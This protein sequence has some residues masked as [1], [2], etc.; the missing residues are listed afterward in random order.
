MKKLSKKLLLFEDLLF[1]LFIFLIPSQLAYH[2]W[3]N[4]AFLGGVRVDYYAPAIYL[5]D[6]LVIAFLTIFV[7]RTV[8]MKGI[9]IR[10][11]S[12]TI[13]ILGV[14]TILI[15]ANIYYSLLPILSLMKWLKIFEL[16]MIALYIKGRSTFNVRKL[17]VIPLFYSVVVF[18]VIG[19]C[20]FY[21]QRS[22]GGL[23]YMLGERSFTADTIGIAVVNIFGVERLRMYSTFPHPN[24]LAGYAG[25]VVIL[26]LVSYK[27]KIIT[28]GKSLFWLSILI[29]GIVLFLTFSKT[30]YLSIVVV[31]C[32]Y[33]LLRMNQRLFKKVTKTVF[34]FIVVL[35][36]L[37]TI[38]S[39]P[40][41]NEGKY[42]TVSER[43]VLA[44][45]A[46]EAFSE[47]IVT[48][49]GMNG[50]IVQL[51]KRDIPT[52]VRW[53]LQP[54]H[55]IY[56]L[57]LSEMGLL[58]FIIAIFALFKVLAMTLEIKSLLIFPYLFILITGTLD[59]YWITLQQN[60]L[61]A[62][63]IIAVIIREYY[64]R[65]FKRVGGSADLL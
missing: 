48:G 7:L 50:Y 13:V 20:Q 22:I 11:R 54:V 39:S 6:I 1:I 52:S 62:T 30:A 40:V 21:Y 25:V 18:G 37:F 53:M 12:S 2:F 29:L 47:N 24:A 56:L 41:V 33:L 10:I 27:K 9:R 31:G 63:I 34:L 58:L 38:I 16:T 49:V 8:L 36:L 17:L 64:E 51:S 4:W 59:H 23:F 26:L 44:N 42:K 65:K 57:M 14:L 19:I 28:S 43:V 35:S 45:V 5:T 3:P 55:N 60:Q 46:G 61:I 15:V 32:M